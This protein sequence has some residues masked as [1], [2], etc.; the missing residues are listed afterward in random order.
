MQKCYNI[1]AVKCDAD[2]NFEG[3]NFEVDINCT[4]D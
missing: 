1:V 3:F 2:I 4:K